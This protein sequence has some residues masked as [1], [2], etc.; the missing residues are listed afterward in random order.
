MPHKSDDKRPDLF[1]ANLRECRLIGKQ[2]RFTLQMELCNIARLKLLLT[3]A[4]SLQK[5][6][7]KFTGWDAKL[8]LKRTRK[9]LVSL[10]ARREGDPHNRLFTE[11]QAISSSVDPQAADIFLGGFANHLPEDPMKMIGRKPNAS[12]QKF[13]SQV[14]L[15]M[16]LDMDESRENCLLVLFV[17]R[18]NHSA[19]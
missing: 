10:E 18:K 14:T 12:R 9:G 17:G 13:Q 1:Q 15:E 2:A 16:R 5:V 19:S 4:R 3:G 11:L 6:S 8:S 7:A